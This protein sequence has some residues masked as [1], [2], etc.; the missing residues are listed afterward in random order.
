[1]RKIE[2][3][4]TDIQRAKHNNDWVRVGYLAAEL[5]RAK[6]NPSSKSPLDFDI[7]QEFNKIFGGKL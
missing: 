1:M 6:K 7:M 5:K 3:I 4:T 2:D